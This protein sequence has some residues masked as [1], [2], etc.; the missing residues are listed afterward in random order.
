MRI[1]IDRFE[2][3]IAVVELDNEMLNV[4]RGLFPGAREGDAVEI[5]VL[6]KVHRTGEDPRELFE[7]LREQS[8]HKKRQKKN[9]EKS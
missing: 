1:I 5:T 9:A 2:G 3:D 7:Q 8:K 6:G 4:P